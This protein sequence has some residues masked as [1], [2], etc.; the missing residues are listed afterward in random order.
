MGDI[1]E[2]L[3]AQS[4]I[5]PGVDR[6]F[7]RLLSNASDASQVFITRLPDGFAGLTYR[8]LVRRAVLARAPFTICGFIRTDPEGRQIVVNPHT[9][10]EPGRD[11]RLERGDSLVVISGSSPRLEPYLGAE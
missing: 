5:T 7:R 2:K 8:D 9:G 10:V 3:I 1:T 6:V 11:S 4:C